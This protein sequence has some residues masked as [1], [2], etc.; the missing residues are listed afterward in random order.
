[1][2]YIMRWRNQGGVKESGMT[3]WILQLRDDKGT[4]I[5]TKEDTT[6]SNLENFSDVEIRMALTYTETMSQSTTNKM[7][8]YF[9]S[10]S[11]S[12]KLGELTVLFDSTKI[13]L[14]VASV[15]RSD[16]TISKFTVPAGAKIKCLDNN[17]VGNASYIYENVGK[18]K[19]KYTPYQS[20]SSSYKVDCGKYTYTGIKYRN[21]SKDGRCGPSIEK[22]C[23]GS[24]CC[25]EYGWCGGQKGVKSD[26]C[27]SMQKIDETKHTLGGYYNYFDGIDINNF[28]MTVKEDVSNKPCGT[29]HGNCPGNECCKLT[30]WVPMEGVCGGNKPDKSNYC[31]IPIWKWSGGRFFT[32][33]QGTGSQY[34][35]DGS[36]EESPKLMTSENM[37]FKCKYWDPL[38]NNGQTVY[39]WE[40]NSLKSIPSVPSGYTV[41][42][43]PNC[44]GIE[45]GGPG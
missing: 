29:G 30:K 12:T 6:A 26:Y 9:D 11:D 17:P 39:K 5:K 34:D 23:P 22:R 43:L 16:V 42:T 27:T 37:V 35:G 45:Y 4:L 8:I 2:E 13:P 25:S 1:M 38:R 18:D 20:F 21:E 32:L 40:N 19:I 7:M 14:D 15:A 31:S 33:W 3:K 41:Y 10:V 44:D 28:K 24:Q 36:Y